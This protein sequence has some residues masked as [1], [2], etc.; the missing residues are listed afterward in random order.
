MGDMNKR[1]SKCFYCRHL[2]C[3]ILR[4]SQDKSNNCCYPLCL[5]NYL[6]LNWVRNHTLGLSLAGRKLAGCLSTIR[7]HGPMSLFSY[8]GHTHIVICER[9]QQNF[10]LHNA[11]LAL[12][13]SSG[14]PSRLSKEWSL[15]KKNSR[16]PTC[17]KTWARNQ[18]VNFIQS[19]LLM[20]KV[21]YI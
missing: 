19:F 4:K 6:L 18:R 2:F 16:H 8:L 3:T 9:G 13:V 10:L 20:Q 15:V 12:M 11:K 5:F 7:I 17:K 14:R 21:T 1:Y